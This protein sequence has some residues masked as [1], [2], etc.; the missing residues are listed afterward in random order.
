M[1]ARTSIAVL[2][3][4]AL[5]ALS[6]PVSAMDGVKTGAAA[7]GGWRHD[8]PGVRRL[9]TADD[10]A[11]A[12]AE[13]RSAGNSPQTVA[14]PDGALPQ[15]KDGFTIE[16]VMSGL[17]SPRTLLFAPNGDLFVANSFAGEIVALRFADGQAVPVKGWTFARNLDQPYGLAFYP[18]ED[19]RW[20]YVATTTG[21]IRYPYAGGLTAEGRGEVLFNDMPDGGHWTRSIAFSGDGSTLYYSVGS[22][23]NVA[24]DM[25]ATPP[26]GLAA[27]QANE[28]PGATWGDEA[29]RAQVYAMDPDGTNRRVLATGLRNCSGLAVQPATDTAW[30]SVNERDALGNDIPFDYVTSVRDGAFYGWP[31]FYIGAN[32]DPRHHGARGDLAD[33]VTVPD[34]LLQS[35]SAPLNLAFYDS[36]A[37]G[38]DYRG[39]A[40][41]A[42]HG[43]WNR[44]P[45]TGYKIVRLLFENGEPTGVYEDFVTGF[46]RDDR[47][48]WGRPVG[49]AVSPDGALYFS[50]D[51][52]GTIWRVTRDPE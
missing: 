6:S 44:D 18:P 36:D 30:C 40:F 14:Q 19:P 47:A 33:A 20:L 7:F 39:D 48:V 16:P 38:A 45:R 10:I 42:L 13:T 29:G 41:V 50:E 26:G 32:P 52:N 34:V 4:A 37:W 12:G 28:A 2:T 3:A 22:Q 49:V 25:G 8:A 46:V 1:T 9:I 11:A 15:V 43:S 23:S 17:G 31:W 27:W 5:F 21:L 24:E 51:G 35:H